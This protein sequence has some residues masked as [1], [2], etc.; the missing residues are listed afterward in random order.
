MPPDRLLLGL[1]SVCSRSVSVG[2]QV[3]IMGYHLRYLRCGLGP[4]GGGACG[5]VGKKEHLVGRS[6]ERVMERGGKNLLNADP[7][8]HFFLKMAVCPAMKQA[9][10]PLYS[11]GWLLCVYE[12]VLI[13]KMICFLKRALFSRADTLAPFYR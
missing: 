9:P 6:C 11:C 3:F 2:P 4:G 12:S 13:L 8:P 1:P 10:R 7:P 5:Y